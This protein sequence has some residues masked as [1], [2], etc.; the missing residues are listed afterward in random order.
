MVFALALSAQ[1]D[2][3]YVVPKDNPYTTAADL[4]RGEQL[5]RGQCAGCHGPTGEGGKG[6]ILAQP[7][8]RRGPDD[9]SL[10][11]SE[12]RRVGKECRL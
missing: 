1:V 10:F 6:A 4:Q 3:D 2:P 5:F 11:R 9:E 12:E 7:R 8:L